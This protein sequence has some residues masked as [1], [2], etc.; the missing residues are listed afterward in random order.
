MTRIAP[1]F[2]VCCLASATASAGP[3][4]DK[5]AEWPDDPNPTR[6]LVG[7]T[8]RSLD[9][10]QVYL[11]SFGISLP[12]VQVGIT[13]RVSMG[14]GAPLLFPG[15][16]P[17]DVFWLTPKVQVFRGEQNQAAVGVFH[18]KAGDEASGIAYGVMTHGAPDGAVTLGV[19]YTYRA[20]PDAEGGAAIVMIGGERRVSPRVKLITENYLSRGGGLVNGGLR[21]FRSHASIDL[22]LGAAFD[23]S[24]VYLLPVIRLAYTF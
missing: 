9:Q 24:G 15:V 7:P 8:A 13:N 23:G 6:L 20:R 3:S 5:W 22:G 19:G 12:F 2:F 10:G 11:D 4:G 18:V 21:L 14:A 16:T 17:G 1:L